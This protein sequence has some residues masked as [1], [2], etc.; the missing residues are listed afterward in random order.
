[1]FFEFVSHHTIVLIAFLY[2]QTNLIQV[3]LSRDAVLH[4]FRLGDICLV[5]EVEMLFHLCLA[6]FLAQRLWDIN[7]DPH[8]VVISDRDS[9]HVSL[10]IVPIQ[11]NPELLLDLERPLM[12]VFAQHFLVV[13]LILTEDFLARLA[14][15][16][17]KRE[18]EDPRQHDA[19]HDFDG[20]VPAVAV[21]RQLVDTI[22]TLFSPLYRKQC[23]QQPHEN[24]DYQAE[25]LSLEAALFIEVRPM[26]GLRVDFIR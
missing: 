15:E 6:V 16:V 13:R 21:R 8:C 3:L 24:G 5:H 1:M 9:H 22:E 23:N 12:Q 19:H 11:G 10:I 2:I 4:L 26:S 17:Q 25:Q 14:A 20:Y 7:L 18:H